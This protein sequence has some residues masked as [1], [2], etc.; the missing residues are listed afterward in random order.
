MADIGRE[1]TRRGVEITA[2][3]PKG[4]NNDF[5]GTGI[6]AGRISTY[7]K[8]GGPKTVFPLCLAAKIST[9]FLK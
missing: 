8:E 3:G 6:V 1:A 5:L 2:A 9:Y 4:Q 7:Q